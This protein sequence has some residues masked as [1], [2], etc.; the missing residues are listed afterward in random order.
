M[1][2]NVLAVS[3]VTA[4][5]LLSG[6]SNDAEDKMGLQ[7][8]LDNGNNSSVISALEDKEVRTDNENLML[9]SAYMDE[10]GFSVIDL[11]GIIADGED[12]SFASFVQGVNDDKTPETLGHLQKA[13][14]FYKEIL[15]EDSVNKAPSFA[16]SEGSADDSLENFETVKLYL[17][18]AYITKVSTVMSY[19]GDVQKWEHNGTDADLMATGCAMARVYNPTTPQHPNCT[20]ITKTGPISYNDVKYEGLEISIREGKLNK[21]T[22]EPYYPAGTYY[23]LANGSFTDVVLTDY[24][25]VATDDFERGQLPVIDDSITIEEALTKTL[26]DGFDSI[27]DAAPEDSQENVRKYRDEIDLDKNKEISI[28]EFTAYM[29]SSTK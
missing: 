14:K 27:I 25:S 9:A 10:A 12:S 23:R 20:G 17:G 3:A 28:E 18:L 29:I 16:T 26:T 24:E 6:C 8:D 19:M 1:I 11:V 5:L 2:K 15:D 22:G 21:E 4:M 13:I 7:Q